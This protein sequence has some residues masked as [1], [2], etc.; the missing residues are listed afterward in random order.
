[1]FTGV[2]ETRPPSA[3]EPLVF[4]LLRSH[5][6]QLARQLLCTA[7]P[8]LDFL[9]AGRIELGHEGGDVG[10]AAGGWAIRAR[11]CCFASCLFSVFFVPAGRV[12]ASNC[13]AGSCSGCRV[14]AARS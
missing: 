9:L 10:L 6:L 7:P 3:P 11:P 2:N 4:L 13:G 5:S 1:M 14:C 12:A 8:L